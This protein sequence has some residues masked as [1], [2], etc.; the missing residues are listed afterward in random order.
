MPTPEG[1]VKPGTYSISRR[2]VIGAGIAGIGATMLSACLKANPVDGPPID[3]DPIVTATVARPTGTVATGLTVPI[4][5][6]GEE[7]FLYVPTGYVAST[8]APLVLMFHAEGETA[9]AAFTLFQPYAD[10]AGLV[11][12][13]VDSA[14]TTWDVFA[15]GSFGP[16]VD[17]MNA[18]LTAVFKIVNVDAARIAVEGYS[19]GGG[20]AVAVG[21]ANGNFFSHV[22]SFSAGFVPG[23][24]PV[25]RP[26]FFLAQ[27]ISDVAID[28]TETG[29]LINANLL[30]G[31][32][33]VEYVRYD[34]G[35]AP[36]TA[37]IQQ[38]IAWLAS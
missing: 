20:Y 23:A 5:G 37:V 34:G 25:G 16:D 3:V 15:N 11:L 13:A 36:T 27:G 28:I 24:T 18:A 33:T 26:K 38:A 1:D 2:E 21:R 29:D 31:G 32:Y 9:Y 8:P 22:I 4:S 35:H 17:F 19:E 10:A 7:A 6:G 30:A 12:L 14:A